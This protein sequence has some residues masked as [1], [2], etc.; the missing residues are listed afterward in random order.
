MPETKK[1]PFAEKGHDHGHCI[2]DALRRADA[3]CDGEGV[4]L[5]Q[6]RRRVLE[7]VWRSHKPVGAYDLLET[8]RSEK[9]GAQPPTVYRAL[10]FLME[11]GLVHRIESMNAYIGCAGPV[12][13]HPTRFLICRECGKAAEINNQGLEQAIDALA[14]ETGFMVRSSTVEVEGICPNCRSHV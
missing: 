1:T 2:E 8:L 13:E 3:L 4:R 14:Q 7:L 5:T 12:G 6:L 10:D 11:H 9:K